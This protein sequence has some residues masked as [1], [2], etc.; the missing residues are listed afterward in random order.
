MPARRFALAATLAALALA[1]PAAHA[2]DTPCPGRHNP[3]EALE[4]TVCV[5]TTTDGWGGPA[6]AFVGTC[7]TDPC[8][9]VIVPFEEVIVAVGGVANDVYD[10]I[11]P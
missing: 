11:T 5:G 10:L 6:Y 1:A 9:V 7:A 2:E 4:P 8:T 3:T